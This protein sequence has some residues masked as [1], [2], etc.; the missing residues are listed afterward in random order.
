MGILEP[1]SREIIKIFERT[2]YAGTLSVLF[3]HTCTHCDIFFFSPGVGITGSIL[4]YFGLQIKSIDFIKTLDRSESKADVAM[5]FSLAVA[6]YSSFVGTA[7]TL[8]TVFTS[9]CRGSYVR[10]Y[11]DVSGA[12]VIKCST[13]NRHSFEFKWFHIQQH[14]PH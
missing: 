1:Q 6:A 3:A 12:L 8:E 5:S 7:P 14:K 4:P 13:G 9:Q 2:L 11:N 10:R